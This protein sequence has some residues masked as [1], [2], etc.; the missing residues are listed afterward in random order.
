MLMLNADDWNSKTDR[1]LGWDLSYDG[2]ESLFFK[3]LNCPHTKYI[4]GEDIKLFEERCE[5]NFQD[6]IPNY[7]L[8]GRISNYYKDVWYDKTEIDNLLEECRKLQTFV[9]D[10]SSLKG[11]DEIIRACMEAQK[12]NLGLFLGAD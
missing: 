3:S 2:W 1:H 8:L 11:L 7:P 9:I 5:K 6:A 12:S 4:Q 10:F